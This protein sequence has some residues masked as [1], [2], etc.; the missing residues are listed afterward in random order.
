MELQIASSIKNAPGPLVL[1][2]EVP[3][4]FGIFDEVPYRRLEKLVREM[5]PLSKEELAS[6]DFP[7]HRCTRLVSH[8]K[9][10]GRYL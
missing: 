4:W 9:D 3:S 10:T 5:F 6:D 2:L 7:L 1:P 8:E